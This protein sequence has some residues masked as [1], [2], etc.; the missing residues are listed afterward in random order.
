MRALGR[1]SGATAVVVRQ[2]NEKQIWQSR[3]YTWSSFDLQ[4]RLCVCVC[5]A[6]RIVGIV[7]TQQIA[8]AC[9]VALPSMFESMLGRQPVTPCKFQ[10]I[11]FSFLSNFTVVRWT[12]L[13]SLSNRSTNIIAIYRS[14]DFRMCQ[15]HQP[16]PQISLVSIENETQ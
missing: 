1:S 4:L 11:Y 10:V 5:G 12:P 13:C 2:Q 6:E 15:S 8:I 7:C 16:E 14:I 3:G 9:I